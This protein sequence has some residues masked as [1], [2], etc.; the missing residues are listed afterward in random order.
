LRLILTNVGRDV[1]DVKAEIG[2]LERELGRGK[3]EGKELEKKKKE[4]EGVMETL[5]TIRSFV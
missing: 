3:T 1:V 2:E 4:I 5:N